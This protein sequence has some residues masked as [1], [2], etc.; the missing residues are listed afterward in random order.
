M[1]GEKAW[2]VVGKGMATGA[3]ARVISGL[4]AAR[5]KPCP[6]EE[7][8]CGSGVRKETMSSVARLGG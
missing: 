2:L 5:L 6:A 7:C 3:K 4:L 1:N 8:A